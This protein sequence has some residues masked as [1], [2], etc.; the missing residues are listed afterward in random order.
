MRYVAID[1][2][3]TGLDT[4]RCQVLEIAMVLETTEGVRETLRPPPK[5]LRM[6]PVEELPYFHGLVKQDACWWEAGA[7]RM[8][9]ELY[10]ETQA[11]GGPEE[12]AWA[13]AARWLAGH[14]FKPEHGFKAVAA[15][16]NVAAFDL[17][18]FPDGVREFFDHRCLD[19]GSVFVD[20]NQDR[21][22]SLVELI[23]Q[24][25][26]TGERHRALHDARAVVQALRKAYA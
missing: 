21:L 23:P 26:R 2:E 3:T 4:Q 7:L 10:W 13:Q 14:G 8:N 11:Q 22:P 9:Q 18:F 24:E 19:P 12:F 1:L 6:Q 20:W 5:H 17:Q 16:K 25:Q 15:G